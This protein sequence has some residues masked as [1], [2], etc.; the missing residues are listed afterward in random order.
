MEV[1]AGYYVPTIRGKRVL[2]APRRVKGMAQNYASDRK[3][4]IEDTKDFRRGL[5]THIHPSDDARRKFDRI[6]EVTVSQPFRYDLVSQDPINLS[7]KLSTSRSTYIPDD[8]LAMSLA[9]LRSERLRAPKK[10]KTTKRKQP[11]QPSIV[12]K[13]VIAEAAVKTADAL[14]E[15]AA[16]PSAT[17]LDKEIAIAASVDAGEILK[18]LDLSALEQQQRQGQ[19]EFK[20]RVEQFLPPSPDK[21]YY[22][23]ETKEGVLVPVDPAK[24]TTRKMRGSKTQYILDKKLAKIIISDVPL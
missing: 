6:E 9:N 20:Q 23:H 13:Q 24:L 11:S 7:E 17:P 1:I 18:D 3:K 2:V 5:Y 22:Y 14:A 19:Q 8:R 10:P 15:A 12:E 16:A 4:F 21:K